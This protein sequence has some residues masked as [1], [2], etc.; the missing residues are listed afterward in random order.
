MLHMTSAAVCCHRTADEAIARL[1]RTKT[2]SYYAVFKID[3]PALPTTFRRTTPSS[4]SCCT[5]APA[6][7]RSR[8]TQS[9]RKCGRHTEFVK[10][11]SLFQLAIIIPEV[12]M[13]CRDD[14]VL[15]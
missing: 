3:R 10:A 6:P 15:P 12:L 1:L 11:F 4:S 5:R 2:I 14:Y 13:F 7:T 8:P 9:C